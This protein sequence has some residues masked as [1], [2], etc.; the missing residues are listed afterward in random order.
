MVTAEFMMRLELFLKTKNCFPWLSLAASIVILRKHQ[1]FTK[2]NDP[3]LL[4]CSTKDITIFQE[5]RRQFLLKND[6]TNL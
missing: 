3:G 4:N 6:S 2:V 1:E 5:L